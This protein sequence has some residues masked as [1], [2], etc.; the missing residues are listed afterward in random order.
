MSTY[1]LR[2]SNGHGTYVQARSETGARSAALAGRGELTV[3]SV[4]RVK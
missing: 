3:L 1:F 2:L 4:R